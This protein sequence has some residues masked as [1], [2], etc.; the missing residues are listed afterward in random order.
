MKKILAAVL[1]GVMLLS[2]ACGAEDLDASGYVQGLLDAQ[3][4][5]EYTAYA[6]DIGES[7]E[8]VKEEIEAQNRQDIEDM[9]TVLGL[10]PTEEELQEFVDLIEDGF[11]KIEYT[12]KEA[13]KDDNG[14]YTV[15]VEVTPVGLLDSVNEILAQK[16]QGEAVV[17]ESGYM[18][19]FNEAVKESIEQAAVYEKETVTLN[20]TYTEDGNNRVYSANESDLADLITIA[21]HQQ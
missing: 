1:A 21:V 14:N 10:T 16:L 5:G 12:V 11:K 15:D 19:V 18:T 4:R 2:A 8:S 9:V 17:D 7:E 13:V 20:I 3:L 6:E